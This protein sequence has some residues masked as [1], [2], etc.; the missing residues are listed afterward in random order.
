MQ[1]LASLNVTPEMIKRYN[2]PGPRYTSYPTVP[3]WKEGKFA[4]NYAECLKEEGKSER[5]ISLYVHIPF[6]R[7]LCTFCGCNKFIT[8]NQKIV[9]QYLTAVDMEITG[10]TESL[11]GRK[12]LAQVHFGGGTPTFLNGTQLE[13]LVDMIQSRFDVQTGC[14]WAL[15]ADPRVT[16]DH[17]LEILF[18]LGFRRVSF[19]VQD[20]DTAIQRA[21][22]RNQTVEQSWRTLET[23]RRLGYDSINLDLVYG[24]PLQTSEGF[25]KTLEEVNRMRPDRLAVYSFAF[26][27]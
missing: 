17:Q 25:N 12:V 21:I 2:R 11:G 15:E 3:V 20:L 23:A 14:E 5:P 6:C 22:N 8:N 18:D 9:E 1:Q 26:L 16:T 7:Q 27:L 19:G 13:R 10:I 4:E 24:L